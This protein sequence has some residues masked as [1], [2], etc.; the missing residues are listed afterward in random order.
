MDAET[1]LADLAER[2][3]QG[4]D[5]ESANRLLEE[6]DLH[7]VASLLL[8][9]DP[10]L[11]SGRIGDDLAMRA[12]AQ[13]VWEF[14]HRA[15]LTKL[16]EVLSEDEPA[17][18][19]KGSALAYTLYPVAAHRARGDTD[20]LVRPE[21]LP[22]L[23]DAL[24]SVG[25]CK[26]TTALGPLQSSAWLYALDGPSGMEHAID[27]HWQIDSS[28]MISRL[29]PFPEL[30][31][32]AVPLP[33]LHPRALGTGLV[34]SLLIACFHRAKH[35]ESPYR[36]EGVAHGETD[37]LIWLRDIH[38]LSGTLAPKDWAEV[39][40]SARMK[41]VPATLLD[42]LSAS[43]T[44]FGTALPAEICDELRTLGCGEIDTYLAARGPMGR[45]WRTLRSEGLRRTAGVAREM[46]FPPRAYMREEAYPGGGFLPW[47]YL[48]RIVGAVWTRLLGRAA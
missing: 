8:E 26:Q 45:G 27:L 21:A 47:L 16:F 12:A 41:G 17:I 18:V 44:A 20:L 34:D 30:L 31:E 22:M 35:Q 32:H 42:G 38:L 2:L 29:W 24:Q 43:R 28:T 23:D 13:S 4:G 3:H 9:M 14:E 7:G 46:I 10:Q 36:T 48:K 15:I 1:K 39:V 33:A 37:R 25:F 5:Q 40:A 19:F 11:A 6:V